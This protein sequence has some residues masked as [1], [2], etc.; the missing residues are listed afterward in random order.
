[1]KFL[2]DANISFRII[3]KIAEVAPA[4]LHVS[5]AGLNVPAKDSEIWNY[6]KQNGFV[7]VSFDEDFQDLSNMY[8]FPPKVIL[9]RFGNVPTEFISSV[10]I[11]KWAQ[12]VEFYNSE[13]A[14]ILEIF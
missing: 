5:R 2:F 14:G 9:L 6:A 11:D 10:L 7:L 12:L 1:M 3:K 8:G 13:H 4:S